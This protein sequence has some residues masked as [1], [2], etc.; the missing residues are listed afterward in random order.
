MQQLKSYTDKINKGYFVNMKVHYNYLGRKVTLEITNSTS[1]L[2]ESIE[3]SGEE[4]IP[5]LQLKMIHKAGEYKNKGM[6]VII[7]PFTN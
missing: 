5:T 1:I 3:L 2:I 7:N 6:E 4:N